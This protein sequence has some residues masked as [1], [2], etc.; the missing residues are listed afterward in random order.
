[1]TLHRNF[2][3]FYA[4]IP[5]FS[6]LSLL[7]GAWLMGRPYVG[8]WGDSV[9]YTAQALNSLD[10]EIL[11]NDI[12]FKYGSQGDFTLFPRLHALFIEW[13]GLEQSAFVLTLFGK[14]IW[15]FC[16]FYFISTLTKGRA[17]IVGL[18]LVLG[19]PPHYDG[20]GIFLYGESMLT[21]RIYAE[22]LVL[23]SVS[24]AIRQRLPYAILLAAAALLLHPLIALAGVLFVLVI[25]LRNKGTIVILACLSACLLLI[26]SAAYIGIS[27]FDRLFTTY[28]PAWLDVVEKRNIF[29]FINRWSVDALSKIGLVIILLL[30]NAH[31]SRG[32]MKWLS[33]WLAVCGIAT[34]LISWIGTSVFSNVL[35]TQLQPWRVLWFVQL[36]ALAMLGKLALRL[37][38]G[39]V[40]QRILLILLGCAL[41]LSGLAS[42]IL[43]A[44]AVVFYWQI[45]RLEGWQPTRSVI[46]AV[47]AA[48]I[49][50]L[51]VKLAFLELAYTRL[52]YEYPYV[53]YATLSNDLVLLLLVLA[54]LWFSSRAGKVFKILPAIAA[55]A[56]LLTGL[57]KFDSRSQQHI[58]PD[59]EVID[60]TALNVVIPKNATVFWPGGNDLSWLWL[61][62]A[63]YVSP[64]QMAG[65]VFS[66][67][68]SLEARR[69]QKV[70]EPFG[71]DEARYAWDPNDTTLKLTS[72]WKS[73][74]DATM[75][76]LCKDQVLDFII[77]PIEDEHPLTGYKPVFSSKMLDVFSCQTIRE[78]LNAT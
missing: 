29:V 7:F 57:G 75:S 45:G 35:I 43:G 55:F 42:L 39:N 51:V 60:K 54:F 44:F 40:N 78:T 77:W 76:A 61:Q 11:G 37:W 74:A 30:V 24:L 10:P 15:F 69:R 52:G 62:R 67:E 20:Y 23:L 9:L 59:N 32:I 65:V 70:L 71:F 16:L 49:Y 1:M 50:S 17:L 22:S 8:I 2:S 73:N 18:A 48:V 36:C 19:V 6:V 21:S 3:S 31:F 72:T 13:L 25:G 56:V 58:D 41:L 12:F 5:L 53:L 27:P 26:L 66:R 28:D 38:Q 47:G 68:V 63:H 33:A 34:V 14:L 64:E 4:Q 46:I